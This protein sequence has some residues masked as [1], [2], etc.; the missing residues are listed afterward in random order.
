MRKWIVALVTAVLILALTACSSS[1]GTSSSGKI[2]DIPDKISKPVTITFWHAMNG[3]QE[4]ALQQ[5]VKE[6]Q[7]THKNITVKLVNQGNYSDLSTKLTA[8]AKAHTLPVMAQAYEN[9]MSSYIKNNQIDDLTP[10]ENSTKHGWSASDK[11][12]IV[13][14]FL[15]SNT[16]NG[17]LYGVPFNKSTEVLFYNTDYLKE[18]K[19]SVPQ[20]WDQLKNAATKLTGT[21][22]KKKVVGLGFEN[23]I[24]FDYPA[25]VRQA[26]G[27]YA[28]E[29][30]NKLLFNSA[31]GKDALNF[32][33]NMTKNGTARLAG[34][35]NYMSGPFSNGDVAMYIGSS[36]GM[37]FVQSGA[38][39]KVNWATAPLPKGKEAATPFQ[40]TNLVMFSSATPDQKLA[41]W[42]L[43]KY[44]SDKKPTME[45]AKATGY[46][47]VRKSVLDDA[48]WESF[49]KE[50][51]EYAAA[52]KQFDS[53]FFEFRSPGT[54]QVSNIL[55][56][57][58]QAVFLNKESVEKGL[59]SA[60]KQGQKVLDQEKDN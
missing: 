47:P 35:D 3:G 15:D 55:T 13:K 8:A 42:E 44:L 34:E 33:T 31:E 36:A 57:E 43:M 4:K 41:A 20:D 18:K 27:Q 45:W 7:Q 38:K 56:K 21:T 29:K 32:L 51:P 12:D 39:G 2:S 25:W 10:Y 50:N 16:F 17:K 6:F 40:G 26:G 9:W 48:E 60:A 23:G 19:L 52:E 14:V 5:L 11:N 1:K 37:S 54:E 24:G 22:G 59:T 53:G 58:M 46:V 30:A 49:I 28:D